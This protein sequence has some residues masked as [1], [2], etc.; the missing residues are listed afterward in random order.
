MKALHYMYWALIFFT[1]I[2]QLSDVPSSIYKA[3]VPLMAILLLLVTIYK[4]KGVLK[5]PHSL[6]VI[7]YVFVSIISGVINNLDAFS[8]IYFLSYTI[9]SY[10]YFVVII[11]ESDLD[12]ITSIKKFVLALALIQ[13]P[14]GVV[15]FFLIGQT[16]KGGIGTMETGAGSL[17][18]IF[19]ALMVAFVIGQ[20][21]Y[22]KKIKYL[23]VVFLY[24]VFGIIGDKR[25]I[26]YIIPAVII[27]AYGIFMRM[28]KFSMNNLRMIIAIPTVVFVVF[29]FSVKTLP[30]LNREHSNWGSFDLNYVF[31][32]TANYNKTSSTNSEE[33][34]RQE[35]LVFFTNHIIGSPP[36]V[37]LFG[38]GAGNLVS[39]GFKSNESTMLSIY[40]V[41]YGGRMGFVWLILQVGILGSALFFLI[42]FRI[43]QNIWKYYKRNSS[44]NP[45][46][47]LGFLTA[48][49]VILWDAMLY[50]NSSVRYEVIKGIYFF[51]AALI[52]RNM[53]AEKNKK[54]KYVN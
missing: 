34:S 43:N 15:K 20:F 53:S 50:S 28:N 17:S 40:G 41:R 35:G 11:N 27:L 49:G 22:T 29:F 46:I 6:L 7:T 24:L 19:P 10:F 2:M 52:Y 54:I 33:V 31:N 21:L 8:V 42:I 32:Y 44:S 18:T 26:V 25:A 13:I 3:G 47:I 5:F 4:C 38:E 16:E 14:A 48:T 9:V 45:A 30:T 36:S 23:I 12:R 39:S 37:F 51:A 1:G